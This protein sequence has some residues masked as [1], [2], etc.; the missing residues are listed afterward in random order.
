VPSFSPRKKTL[1]R[2][3]GSGSEFEIIAI[4]LEEKYSWF[5]FDPLEFEKIKSNLL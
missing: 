5:P 3:V 2:V 4:S 1:F